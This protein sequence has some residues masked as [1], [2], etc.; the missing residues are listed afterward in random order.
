MRCVLLLLVALLAAPTVFADDE[1]TIIND[2]DMF[3]PIT[4]CS[5]GERSGCQLQCE[6]W[7]DGHLW[8]GNWFLSVVCV[9]W[10]STGQV[11]CYCNWWSAPDGVALFLPGASRYFLLKPA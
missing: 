6:Q 5:R 8:H 3:M 10:T 4:S 2:P 11:S 9:K 7:G 1:V